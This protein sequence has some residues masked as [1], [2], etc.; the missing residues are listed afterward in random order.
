[1]AVHHGAR[2]VAL[3]GDFDRDVERVLALLTVPMLD[4][5]GA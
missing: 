1:V 5:I 3:A 2:D 4:V